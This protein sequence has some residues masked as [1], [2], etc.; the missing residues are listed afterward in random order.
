MHKNELEKLDYRKNLI[1]DKNNPILIQKAWRDFYSGGSSYGN[2]LV[3]KAY[4]GV[5]HGED[6]LT[7]NVFRSLQLHGPKGLRVIEKTFG[8]DTIEGLLFWGCDVESGSN[9]QQ[10]LNATIRYIDGGI[11]GPVTEPD[12]VIIT[13]SQVVFV[14]CKLKRH[15]L[16]SPWKASSDGSKHRYRRYIDTFGYT[17]L[18]DLGS[19]KNVYQLIRNYVY[20]CELAAE[21]DKSPQVIPLIREEDI[22]FWE[23]FYIELQSREPSIFNQIYS[24]Q[25]FMPHLSNDRFK[26]TKQKL[27]NTLAASF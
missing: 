27:E 8:L 7:W 22:P 19:W 25:D 12:M 5:E 1:A 10:W 13:K 26:V 23:P 16:T 18:D 9:S 4:L 11:K 24:W 3:G 2:S 17:S 6:A 14:E 21:L 15:D 20:A